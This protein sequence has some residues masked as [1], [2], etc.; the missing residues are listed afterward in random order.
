MTRKGHPALNNSLAHYN[1]KRYSYLRLMPLKAITPA[2]MSRRPETLVRRDHVHRP[3][4]DNRHHVIDPSTGYDQGTGTA[5]TWWASGGLG[6]P[7]GLAVGMTGF[8][9]KQRL[10]SSLKDETPERYN[11]VAQSYRELVLP[12]LE[13]EGTFSVDELATMRNSMKL[14]LERFV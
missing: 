7:G 8:V 11:A 4:W 3:S 1:S 12:V 10:V 2:R 14:E 9:P 13:D 5:Q 6:G